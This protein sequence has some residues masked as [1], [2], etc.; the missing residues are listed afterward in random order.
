M[1]KARFEKIRN[2]LFW[3]YYDRASESTVRW[4]GYDDVFWWY[5]VSVT[6]NFQVKKGYRLNPRTNEV[7]LINVENGI[8]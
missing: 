8:I 1:I 2:D 4:I 6:D 3:T 7:T 5:Q